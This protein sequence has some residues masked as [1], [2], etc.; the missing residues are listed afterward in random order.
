MTGDENQYM[1]RYLHAGQK[2]RSGWMTTD[3]ASALPNAAAVLFG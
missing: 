2:T 1:L 3:N